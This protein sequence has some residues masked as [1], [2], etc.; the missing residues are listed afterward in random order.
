MATAEI[1]SD[2]ETS[3][4]STV[5][6]HGVNFALAAFL[7]Q[8][9]LKQDAFQLSETIIQAIYDHGLQ[10]RTP[11]TLTPNGTFQG[12]YHSSALAIWALV[13]SDHP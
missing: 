13:F 3:T 4:Q 11:E 12:S 6:S 10:F 1:P 2:K 7:L 9:G 8:L 5:I